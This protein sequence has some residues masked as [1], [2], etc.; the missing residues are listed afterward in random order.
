MGSSFESEVYRER[1]RLPGVSINV[2]RLMREIL[3][4]TED[5]G[6]EVRLTL[7]R[8]RWEIAAYKAGSNEPLLIA[9]A[10]ELEL[11]LFRAAVHQRR[12]DERAM[13]YAGMQANSTD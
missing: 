9:W 7:S 13:R 11:C 4:T 8:G 2:V 1:Q 12:R 10:Q 3:D 6:V 5:A